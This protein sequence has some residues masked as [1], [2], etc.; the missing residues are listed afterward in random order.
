MANKYTALPIPPREELE[1]L[2]HK[3]FM[4]QKEIGDHYNVSQKVVFSWFQKQNIQSRIPYKRNQTGSANSSWKGSE[5][6]YAALHYRVEAER[7][8]PSLCQVCGTMDNRIYEWANLTGRYDDI[9]DYMRM[10]RPCHRQ[11]DKNRKNSSKHV[12]RTKK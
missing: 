3:K 7:G 2:Y 1:E 8:K 12:S 5:A 4:S 10:C 11:Y 9:N 6:T